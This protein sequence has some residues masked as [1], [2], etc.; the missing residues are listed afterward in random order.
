MTTRLFIAR[1]GNTFLP[2]ETPRRLGGETDLD[3]VEE[4]RARAVGKY[5]KLQNFQIDHLISAPL[6]RTRQTSDLIAEEINFPKGKIKI[7]NAFKEIDYGPDEDKEEDAVLLRL[8]KGDRQKGQ[9]II[10]AWNKD[11]T[12]PSGWSVNPDD[13][14]QTWRDLGQQIETTAKDQTTLVVSSNGI[15]RFAPYLTENF[16]DFS[17]QFNIK[18]TTGGLCLFEKEDSDPHWRCIEWNVKCLTLLQS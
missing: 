5:L 17:E 9:K 10:D 14:K 6:K 16:Q 18:V 11:A 4:D 2:T 8:G 7:D 15:I 12:V 3:L 13:L 1:H